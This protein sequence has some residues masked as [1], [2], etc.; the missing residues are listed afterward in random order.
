MQVYRTLGRAYRPSQRSSG[1]PEDVVRF[2]ARFE[3]SPIT[4]TSMA[5]AVV[6][7]GVAQ[8]AGVTAFFSQYP[9][10]MFILTVQ[11]EEGTLQS[12]VVVYD[13]FHALCESVAFEVDRFACW[14]VPT[15]ASELNATSSFPRL[16]SCM[17][18]LQDLAKRSDT[19]QTIMCDPALFRGMCRHMHDVMMPYMI[20][21]LLE[22]A[23]IL[24]LE[25]DCMV[26]VVEGS[27][28]MVRVAAD[29]LGYYRLLEFVVRHNYRFRT[30]EHTWMFT[31][32]G[33]MGWPC[34]CGSLVRHL[35]C[36][37]YVSFVVELARQGTLTT[38]Q[39]RVTHLSHGRVA[40]R[41]TRST[42]AVSVK[43]TLPCNNNL[44]HAV[45]VSLQKVWSDDGDGRPCTFEVC[46]ITLAPMA[47]PVVASDGHTYERAAI[48][49]CMVVSGYTSPMTRQPIEPILIPNR[50]LYDVS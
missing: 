17:R 16:H 44:W 6:E 20:L 21:S 41:L 23:L 22:P 36:T 19:A 14:Y 10:D 2:L 46:P 26:H 32:L 12:N 8:N 42:A 40:C 5:R 50:A 39:A 38:L 48:L 35:L 7:T 4:A 37:N 29:A 15:L 18:V 28:S 45:G 3:A 49:K 33:R 1:V 24:V 47:D 34:A 27:M 13:A 31:P 43:L 25:Y 9:L 30:P 11:N